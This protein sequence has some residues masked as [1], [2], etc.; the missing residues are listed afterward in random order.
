MNDFKRTFIIQ[1]D[2]H[3]ARF[4]CINH[5]KTLS[6]GWMVKI[7]M[8]SKTRLQEEKYHAQIADIAKSCLYYNKKADKET[9][10][11]LLVDQF[12]RETITDPDLAPLWVGR[13]V[14]MMLNL[15]GTGVV[16][17]GEQTKLFP[18]LLASA[19][20]EWLDCYEAQNKITGELKWQSKDMK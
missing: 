8:P 9:W 12:R 20:I 1:D 6:T 2:P 14:E 3:P 17:M 15:D 5:I 16:V 10:K 19:F 4:N 11:R 13:G 7:S 18:K